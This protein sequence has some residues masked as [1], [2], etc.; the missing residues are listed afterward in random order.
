M[1]RIFTLA[2]ILLSSTF[3]FSQN[4][5]LILNNGN[6]IV[7]ELKD[8]DRAVVTVETPYSDQDFKIEWDGI[9]ELFTTTSF[10]ITTSSGERYNGSIQSVADGKVRITLDKGGTVEVPFM[11]IVYL[12]SID[13]GF[14]NKIDAF[15]DI[16][17]DLTKA[18][19]VMTLSTRSGINYT[20]SRWSLGLSINTN[21]TT[22]SEGPNT[23]RT[24]G[25]LNYN[26]FLPKD[27]YIP[28]SVTY[29]KSSEQNLNARWTILGGAGYYFF[30]TNRF[31]WGASAGI[32]YNNE[33]YAQTDST[34]D[35]F[36]QRSS[37]AYMGTELNLFDIG[38]F[39]L[40]TK[41]KVFPSLTE[42]GRWRFDM[43]LDT[44]YDL[45]LDF[46]IK[47]GGS[48]NYD[49]KPVSGGSDLDYVFY[50]GFGWEWP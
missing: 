41:M 50:T 33:N 32:T 13:K 42:P 23:N 20:A 2:F 12:K 16:G 1:K 45:P 3:V 27:F 37:E 14:W 15:V 5:S 47:L 36:V 31:Y 10:L 35:F 7:G 24:D 40:S 38:D 46:Y 26:Y 6:V 19:N 17:F 22:Q 34:P 29:L 4:D 21:I 9:K 49:N 11:D 39:S 44:K 28:V 48:L 30:H 43:G 8:M 25:A 18:N